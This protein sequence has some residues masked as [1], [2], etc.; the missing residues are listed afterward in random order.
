[1]DILGIMQEGHWGVGGGDWNP[2]MAEVRRNP[3]KSSAEKI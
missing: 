1:M 2:R 3:L